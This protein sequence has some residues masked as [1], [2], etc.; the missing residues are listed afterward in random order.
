MG[1]SR[2][3]NPATFGK[4]RFRLQVVNRDTG[5]SP[6]VPMTLLRNSVK[7]L[8]PW[9]V[10]HTATVTGAFGGFETARPLT[11]VTL[12]A[13]YGLLIGMVWS[14]LGGGRPL[15]DQVAGTAVRHSR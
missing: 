15:H 3:E 12:V 2:Q 5:A 10:G 14:V 8:V 13:S 1:E 9:Q 4:R 6:T 7:I 11:M